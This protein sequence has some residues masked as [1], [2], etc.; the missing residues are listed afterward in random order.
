MTTQAVI[1]SGGKQY[2]VAP[3]QKLLVDKLEGEA[4]AEIAF[5][6]VLLVNGDSTSIGTPYVNGASVKGK[7]VSQDKA[8]KIVVYTYKRRKGYHKKKGHRQ[9]LTRVEI[10]EI[11]M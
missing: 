1:E 6:K 10:M 7:I 8:D 4:G 5:D 3:G 9:K 2:V 11:H